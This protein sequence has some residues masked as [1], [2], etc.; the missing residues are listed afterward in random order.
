MA[1]KPLERVFRFSLVSN[2]KIQSG[3]LERTPVSR[4]PNNL[5]TLYLVPH[6]HEEFRSMCVQAIIAITV[7]YDQEVAVAFEGLRIENLPRFDDAKLA[8]G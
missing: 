3:A 5:V 8:A 7:V 1:G 2:F 6:L 4:P